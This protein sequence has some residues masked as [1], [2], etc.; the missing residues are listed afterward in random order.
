MKTRHV[1]N[2]GCMGEE[3]WG[4]PGYGASEI[5]RGLIAILD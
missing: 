2:E 4:V 1:I 3:N 5:C